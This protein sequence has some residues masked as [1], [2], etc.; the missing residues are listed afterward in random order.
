MGTSTY[1]I[2]VISAVGSRSE[3]VYATVDTG[4]TYSCFPADL[5]RDLRKCSGGAYGPNR[6]TAASSS[7]PLVRPGSS[8][9]ARRSPLAEQVEVRGNEPARTSGAIQ[10]LLDGQSRVTSLYN[11]GNNRTALGRR[12]KALTIWA[13]L[14][15]LLTDWRQP[16]GPGNAGAFFSSWRIIHRLGQRQRTP[17]PGGAI[18]S[19]ADL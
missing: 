10:L 14:R 13:I 17:R 18:G 11:D 5:L 7:I 8:W 2:E 9:K 16:E 4:S 3:T 1:P 6:L 12:Q 19:A 15:S